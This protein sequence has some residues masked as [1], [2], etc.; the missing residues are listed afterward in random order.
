MTEPRWWRGVVKR[1]RRAPQASIPLLQLTAAATLAWFIALQIGTHGEPFFA[2]ISAVVA[3]SSPLGERGS[4]A[5]RLLL[6]VMVG[7]IAGELTVLVLGEGYGRLALAVFVGMAMARALRGPRLVR[8]QAAAAAILTVTASGGEA[9]LHRLADALVGAGVALVFSQVLLSP[10]PVSLVRRASADSLAKIGAALA[11]VA[12][13]LEAGD[14]D[15]ADEATLSL[16]GLRDQLTELARLR[17]ASRRVARRSAIWRGRI[18]PVVQESEN[19]GHLDL[20]ASSCVFF[21]RSVADRRVLDQSS[22]CEALA[23]LIDELARQ[24]SAMG[25]DP[26]D[27]AIRQGAADQALEA[28]RS[29]IG[30][31]GKGAEMTTML[32]AA[33][34]VSL[35]VVTVAGVDPEDAADALRTDTE[36]SDGAPKVPAPPGVP[37]YPFAINPRLPRRPELLRRRRPPS[38]DAG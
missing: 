23:P 16:R 36:R 9:G 11:D 34:V 2:P 14:L 8:V 29:I 6:G 31:S 33:R 25:N 7:I 17:S 27:R 37:R 26:G 21:A 30:L 32:A 19:A 18:E 1:L 12:R 38:D 22:V 13:A 5:I 10:E 28:G 3:L 20:L 24:V 15:Q 4:N 35:D